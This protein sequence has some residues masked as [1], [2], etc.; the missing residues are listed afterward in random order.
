M[1]LGKAAGHDQIITEM[2]KYMGKTVEDLLLRIVQKAWNERKIVKDWEV[3]IIIPIFK[4]GSNRECKNHRGI[5]LLSVPGKIYSRIL[6]TRL[7]QEMENKMEDKMDLGQ[8]E[9]S[10]IIYLH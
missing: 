7:R 8:E 2:I 3:A 4:K 10:K 5:S 9:V 6:E 1:K